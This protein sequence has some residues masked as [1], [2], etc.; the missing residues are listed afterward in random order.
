MT[1]RRK[2]PR[3]SGRPCLS[4]PCQRSRPAVATGLVN[5]GLERVKQASAK[6]EA[7]KPLAGRAVYLR[8]L[9]AA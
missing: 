6:R 8:L 9:G 1:C 4:P 3:R 2:V 7:G 5:W